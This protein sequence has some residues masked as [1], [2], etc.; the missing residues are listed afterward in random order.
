MKLLSGKN[1]FEI[2]I[3]QRRDAEQDAAHEP[4]CTHVARFSGTN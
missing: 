1:L 4:E 2:A 3:V